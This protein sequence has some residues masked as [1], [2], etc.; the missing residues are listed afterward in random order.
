MKIE[1]FTYVYNDEDLIPFFLRHYA[2]IVDKMT[3]IDS[4]STDNTLKLLK[5]Y[6]VVQSGITWW[7]WDAYHI[8]KNNIWRKSEYDLVFFPDLDEFLYHKNLRKFLEDKP[9]D[10]YQMEGFQM[11]S[12]TFPEKNTN[13]LEINKGF[14]LPLHDKFLIFNPRLDFK[15]DTAHTITVISKEKCKTSVREIKLLHYKYL[16]VENMLRRAALI[17]S[18]TPL[19]SYTASIKGNIL[20]KYPSFVRTRKEYVDEIKQMLKK[21]TKV[22]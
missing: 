3:F 22:I 18:R 20:S 15:F 21:C 1:L 13:M 14:P 9:C 6:E 19:D 8:I 17:T 11:V 16:G 2:P 4:A 12:N 7:D 5:K 10:M